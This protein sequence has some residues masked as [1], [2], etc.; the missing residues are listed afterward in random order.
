[1]DNVFQEEQKKLAEVEAKLDAIATKHEQHGKDLQ[2]EILDFYCVDNEDRMRKRELIQEQSSAYK[3]AEKYRGYMLS[4]Y[5]GRLDL[6]NVDNEEIE[7]FYIGKEG[8]S[9]NSKIMVVDWRTPMGSIYYASNQKEFSVKGRNFLLSLKRALDVQNG[10]LI[11]YRTEYDGETVSLEGDVIDPFLLTVLKD[12]RRHNRLTDIIRT[13]QGN[14]NDIIRKDRMESFVVQG[15]AGSGKTMILLH[16]LSFLKFNNRNMS[17]SGVKIITPNKFFDAHINDLSKE[18]G[19]TSIE[20]FSV[21]EYYVY[22]MKRFF[23]KI[24]VDSIVQSEK[25]LSNDLLEKLY[26]VD[27]LD[28]SIENY[29]NYWEQIISEIDEQRL[30][31]L[32]KEINSVY[33]DTSKHTVE[34][35]SLFEQGQ[36]RLSAKIAEIDEKYKQILGRLKTID[37]DIA[38]EQAEFEK[39]SKSMITIKTQTVSRIE[40]ELAAA[41]ESYKKFDEEKLSIDEQK[42]IIQNK[43]TTANAELERNL[44][45]VRAATSDLNKYSNYDSFVRQ[46]DSVS[47]L[48]KNEHKTIISEILD[49]ENQYRK[50]PAYNFS[51]RNALKRKITDSK[52]LFANVVS[53][54]LSNAVKASKST[55]DELR[56][57]IREFDAAIKQLDESYRDIDKQYK[58]GKLRLIALKECLEQ[59][60]TQEYPDTQKRLSSATRKECG[61]MISQYEKQYLIFI[62][63]QQRVKSIIET[64]E[65]LENDKIT[66]ESELYSKSDIEFVENCGKI[67]KKLQFSEISRGV[68]FK[69]LLAA[70]KEHTQKYSKTNYRHKIYLKLLFC[71]LYYSKF[72]NPDNFLNIDEAQDISIAEYKLLRMILGENCVFNLYGDINQSV[73]SYKGITDWDDISDITSENIYILNENYRNTLQI[74]E[75]CNEEFNSEV[76]PIGISGDE[77]SELGI[78]DAVKWIVELKKQNPEYRVAII[79]RHGVLDIQSRLTTLLSGENVSWYSVDEQKLSVLSVE[80]AKGLEFEAIVS[81]VDQMSNNEKYI[82]YTRALDKLCVVREKFNAGLMDDSGAEDFGDDFVDVEETDTLS[83]GNAGNTIEDDIVE[84]ID[85]T[86]ENDADVTSN[87]EDDLN[88]ELSEEDGML[89]AEMQSILQESF[90]D[91]C[92]LLKH[93]QSVLCSLYHGDNVAFSAPSGSM[94]SIILYLLALREHQNS[95]KQS[96]ITAESHLQENELVLA[97]QLGLRGGIIVSSMSDFLEDF[98]KEQY[99]VIFV[100]FD[101][102]ENNN[103]V[104]E[105]I[106]YF[107]GKIAYWGVD[108]PSLAKDNWEKIK[109]CNNSLESTMYLMA[110]DGFE[111]LQLDDFNVQKINTE[112]E[113]SLIKK[114]NFVSGEERNKWLLEN[115]NEL[116]GQGLIYCNDEDTC[117]IIAKT[118]RKNKILAEAYVDVTNSGKKERVNYLT[119]LFSNGGLPIL[120]TTQDIGKNLSNANI[121]FI[122]HYDVPTDNQVYELHI[123]QIGQLATNPV[124]FD[125]NVI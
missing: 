108:H 119:N 92:K 124:V 44:A 96:I 101:F 38:S 14:Q 125:L 15:C 30:K 42:K 76:Y 99:D 120:V 22:L 52:T 80:T 56:T 112:T 121:R 58:Q 50:T 61:S 77:V 5:F 102:F 71:S 62:R 7:T 122:L 70:Y 55:Q 91:N 10:E 75:F 32:F 43:R 25:I 26:S 29:H 69:D 89:I 31:P 98:K 73:Y 123:T 103:N 68:M 116:S 82:S 54:F 85:E 40:L 23:N 28:K 100:P 81:I 21:E 12:K 79:H 95:G 36:R 94:K 84:S 49:A 88:T 24:T 59:F 117:K 45:L 11:T 105:F 118:L 18:L 8:I 86:S 60:S 34:T 67:I 27:Y 114:F 2:A 1:M 93:Q 78:E 16:R 90:G 111:D 33:P 72:L 66:T 87:E 113:T 110:K 106:E 46:N 63:F 35:F 53:E 39:A 51:K 47:V 107:S 65:K 3:T 17:L 19:L 74:T 4:P 109:M 83:S 6:D 48:I 104:K 57:S 41:E 13:I 97:D 20:R 37:K 9:D 115:L 64:K